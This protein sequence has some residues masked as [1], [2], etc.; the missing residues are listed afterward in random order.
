[1]H[2]WRGTHG[3]VSVGARIASRAERGKITVPATVAHDVGLCQGTALIGGLPLLVGAS[4]WEQPWR[5]ANW[6]LEQMLPD[7][8]SRVD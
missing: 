3:T 2:L 8:G 7:D 4:N 1:M 6:R 5:D